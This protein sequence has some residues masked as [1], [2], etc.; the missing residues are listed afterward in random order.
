MKHLYFIGNGFDL[1]HGFDTRYTDFRDWLK[2]YDEEAYENLIWLYGVADDESDETYDWWSKFEE[3]LVDFDVYDDIVEIARE[4]SIDYGADN[5]RE[6]D[7]YSGGVEAEQRFE[8]TMAK[9]LGYFGI[10]V[11]SLG[12]LSSDIEVDLDD[13][14]D[15]INFNYTLTLE[16][17]YNVPADRV[18]HLHGKLGD[19]TYILG[20]G[21]SYQDIDRSIR[22]NE[23]QPPQNL[24]EEELNDW[25]A[26]QW[27]EAYENTVGYTASKLASY[28]KDTGKIIK[29]NVE[30]FDDMTDLECITIYGC[31][32]SEIDAPYFSEAISRVKDR[33]KL[34]FVV[35]WYSQRDLDNIDK[36]FQSEGIADNMVEKIKLDEITTIREI[37]AT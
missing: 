12:D 25:Y 7:R 1:H 30:L 20:H 24:P 18:H 2:E 11:D 26:E 8:E 10:W 37:L 36:F 35:N 33:N 5:F 29:A 4:N 34:M 9:I 22:A 21:R 15:F 32:F 28:K 6:G 27:D 13:D 17:L 16:E 31:S 3:H 23:P 14:A 19:D